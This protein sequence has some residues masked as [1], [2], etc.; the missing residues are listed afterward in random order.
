MVIMGQGDLFDVTKNRHNGADTSHAAFKTTTPESR[1]TQR[2]R[3]LWAISET[4]RWYGVDPGRTCDE[5]E[6][7]TGMSHQTA[8]ARITELVIEGKV[9]DTGIRR[10]TRSGRSARVYE[11]TS[12]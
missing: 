5:V 11:A 1:A 10:K 7:L 9:R 3:V 6:R 8:S 2:S 12:A 4:D